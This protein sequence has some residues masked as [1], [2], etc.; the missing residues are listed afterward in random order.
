MGELSEGNQADGT[1]TSAQKELL[2]AVEQWEAGSNTQRD[3]PTGKGGKAI[4]VATAP[5]GIA[6]ATRQSVTVAA[7]K[8]IDQVAAQHLHATVGKRWAVRAGEAISMFAYRLGMKLVAAGGKLQLLALKDGIDIGAAGNVHVF[9]SG[10]SLVFEAA[11]SIVLRVPGGEVK[12][13]GKFNVSASGGFAVQAPDFTFGQG[14][15]G[16]VNNSLA[17]NK[18]QHDQYVVLRDMNSGNPVPNQRYRITVEDGQVIEGTSDDQ[19]RT[20]AFPSAIGFARYTIE[21]LD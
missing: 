2:E 11:E 19:G 8:N 17:P 20:Q 6:T 10:K 13:D 4:V 16:S 18:Q 14:G 7:G 21:L 9:S 15:G 12:F 5:E 3:N 1:D